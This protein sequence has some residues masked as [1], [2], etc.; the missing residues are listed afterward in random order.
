MVPQP[1]PG[2]GCRV[3]SEQ[4]MIAFIVILLA[5][6]GYLVTGT[7]LARRGLPDM[8]ESVRESRHEFVPE[9]ASLPKGFCKVC[10]DLRE[11]SPRWVHQTSDESIYD[12]AWKDYVLTIWLWPFVVG[13]DARYRRLERADPAARKREL[14]R[15]QS[16]IAELE[17]WNEENR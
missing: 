15:L 5:L 1:H 14:E 6:T 3:E 7:V 12:E 17:T 9:M 8:I 13:L 16:R 2:L 10:G 11:L 4:A